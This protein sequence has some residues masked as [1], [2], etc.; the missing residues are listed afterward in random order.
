VSADRFA[1]VPEQPEAK[2]LLAA[3][4][5]EGPAHAYLL[6][7]PRGVGKTAAARAF[8]AALLGDDERALRER[9]TH[10]DLYVLER[11]G[12]MIRIDDIREL[13]HDLHMRP[14]EA[15]RR[16]Y[17]VADAHLMNEDAADALLKDLEEP[18]AYATILLVADELG[19]L[20]ETVRSRCQLVPFRRL[21]DAAVR[22]WLSEQRPELDEVTRAAVARSSGGRLDRARKLLDEAAAERRL[23]LVEAARSVYL[24]DDFDPAAAAAVVLDAM[25][26]VGDEAKAREQDEVDRR[27]LTGRDAE[28]RVRRAQRGAER[29]ELLASIEALAAW[30]RD[31]VV[32]EAGAE[33]AAAHADRLD[34]LRSDVAAGAADGA[35]EAAAVARQAWR[36]AEE[37]NVNASLALEALFVRLQ[38]A[39]RVAT[40]TRA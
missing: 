29:E 37:F 10:P 39:V 2:R 30:Y 24:A 21:S 9:P 6:H 16:V 19:S 38:R 33:H 40:P 34:D 8:A 17:L 20:P 28:Q 36:E 7:G 4:L 12:E 14:F 18:P 25:R 22:D 15:D 3:A 26:G 13:R 27:D 31:L 35:D 11:V 5:A 1:A 23:R 32:V